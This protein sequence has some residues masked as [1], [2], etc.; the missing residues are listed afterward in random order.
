LIHK[1]KITNIDFSWEILDA[2]NAGTE[3]TL[4]TSQGDTSMHPEE[5]RAGLRV[6]IDC[7][8]PSMG[9]PAFQAGYA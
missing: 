4:C 6:M 3:C 2:N 9:Q 7:I 8:A 5:S 1:D